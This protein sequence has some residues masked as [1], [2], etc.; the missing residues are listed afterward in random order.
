M[1][2]A[3]EFMRAVEKGPIGP[4]Y[5]F[6]PHKP[7]R[8]RDPSFEP[9]LAQ[10]AV[11]RAVEA[12]VDPGLRDLCYSVYYAEEADPAEI[13]SVART[14]PFLAD[15]RVVVIHNAERYEAE[16]VGGPLLEY[17]AEPADTTVMLLVANRIDRRLKLYKA[18]EKGGEIVECPELKDHELALWIHDEVKAVGKSIEPD[19]VTEIVSRTGGRLSEVC[20]AVQL[21]SGYIGDAPTIRADDVAIACAD[22]AEDE[23]WAFTDAIAQSNTHDAI[24]V[25]RQLIDLGK[26]EF[27]IMGMINWLLKTA[28]AVAAGIGSELKVSPYQ[29]GKVRP[30]VEKLGVR[31][32][33]DAFSLCMETEILLRSTGVDRALALEL[34]AIKLAAPRR[35]R[36]PAPAQRERA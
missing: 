5:L 11:A 27:E 1:M 17:L 34:L 25:L 9:L 2:K 28:Y 7:P 31:K 29:A 15:R 23:V 35:A 13:V 33:R 12:L 21:V 30:L 14:F 24:R 18:C 19:A 8:A 4:V 36:K 6:C 3:A 22:V 10:R 26:N 16:S 32:L 20:N